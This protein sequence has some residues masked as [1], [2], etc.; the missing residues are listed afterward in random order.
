MHLV[1]NIAKE[2]K[3]ACR[4]EEDACGQDWERW[5]TRRFEPPPPSFYLPSSLQRVVQPYTCTTSEPFEL[6]DRSTADLRLSLALTRAD[7]IRIE[8][9]A[10]FQ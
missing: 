1:P 3:G 7:A 9:K 6:K 4:N 5:G 8:L 2:Q 10:D